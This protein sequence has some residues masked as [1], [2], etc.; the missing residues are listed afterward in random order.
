MISD[1]LLVMAFEAREI[2]WMLTVRTAFL[3][4]D[5]SSSQFPTGWARADWRETAEDIVK[6]VSM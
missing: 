2:H 1:A 4:L 6:E 3:L 5:V